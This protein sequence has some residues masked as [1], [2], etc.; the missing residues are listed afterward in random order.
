[1]ICSIEELKQNLNIE[2]D[3]KDEDTYLNNLLDVSE[4]AI[5]N[6]LDRT[7]SEFE[8]VPLSIKQGIILLASQMYENRTP[9]AFASVN[10]IPYAFEFLLAPYRKITIA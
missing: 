1:M 5:F 10:K 3:Y 4:E 9:I 6:Y 2:L 7:K 8:T